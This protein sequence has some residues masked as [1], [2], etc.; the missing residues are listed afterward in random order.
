MKSTK[1]ILLLVLSLVMLIG[2][3][4]VCAFAEEAD[5]ATVVYPDG[6]QA[7]VAVGEKIPGV[8]GTLCYA[9]GNTL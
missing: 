1:K 5:A 4:A 6:S 8:D 2:L 3:F 9:P 7:S